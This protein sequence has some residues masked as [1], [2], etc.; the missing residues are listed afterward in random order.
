MTELTPH[1]RA[2]WTFIRTYQQEHSRPPTVR[3]IAEATG[4]SS[5]NGIAEVITALEKK[6][7][8]RRITAGHVKATAR[9]VLAVRP[10]ATRDMEMA[11]VVEI[12]MRTA[13][14]AAY[15][16]GCLGHMASPET[17]GDLHTA[18]E[19]EFSTWW[20]KNRDRYL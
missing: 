17:L 7:W 20:T 3:E 11:T 8:V 18:I 12:K 2:I 16:A 4:A 9:N 6:G 13:A 5:T 10:D 14:F 19:P 1:Q 15:V